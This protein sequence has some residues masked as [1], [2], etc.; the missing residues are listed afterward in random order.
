MIYEVIVMP[1]AQSELDEAYLLLRETEQHA[2]L[3]YNG[4]LDAMQ[5]LAHNPARCR[6]VPQN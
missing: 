2:P 6:I 3:W 4:A 1:A 5:S